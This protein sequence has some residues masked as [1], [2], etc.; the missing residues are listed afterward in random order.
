MPPV[1]YL[2]SSLN[3][4]M[5]SKRQAGWSTSIGVARWGIGEH[6]LP[7]NACDLIILL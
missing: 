1:R 7:V 2:L 4:S 3:L 6:L 5:I